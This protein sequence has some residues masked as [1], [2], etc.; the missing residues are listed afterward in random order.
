MPTTTAP[1]ARPV[2]ALRTFSPRVSTTW[3]GL[4]AGRKGAPGARA[5]SPA[6]RAL[7]PASP[8]EPP[9]LPPCDILPGWNSRESPGEGAAAETWRDAA[10][11]D[12][13]PAI[14]GEGK[15]PCGASEARLEL[16]SIVI[17]G[18][19]RGIVLSFLAIRGAGSTLEMGL[20]AQVVARYQHSEPV[21]GAVAPELLQDVLLQMAKENEQDLRELC[22]ETGCFKETQIVDFVFLLSEKWG[23]PEFARY[24]AIEIFE[25]F[26]LTLTQQFSFSTGAEQEESNCVLAR[27]QIVDTCVLRLVSCIQLASKLSFHYSIVNNAVVLKFLQSMGFSYTTE[28]LLES[29][30]G[31]LKA[32]HFQI[33]VPTPLAYIEML[34]EV[35]GYNG[36]LLPMEQMHAM[37]R[38]LLSLT[39]LLRVS[40][41]STLLKASIENTS[42]NKLQLAKFAAVKEDLMLL[43][44][45]IIGASAFLF[46]TEDWNQVAENLSD[47]TGISMRSIVEIVDAILKHSI[48]HA[49][50]DG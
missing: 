41:Y 24:Q 39:Y 45:G 16:Y 43:A 1:M 7:G 48:G 30:L 5:A 21:F 11:A 28:D 2:R 3:T 20:P 33:N 49:V 10:L 14:L 44:V 26:M 50:D 42:P 13:P 38:H 31:I 32:L 35:L 34:L 29:E 18:G 47:T 40:V 36:C 25:R 27:Q 9:P 37:C 4:E 19:E 46:H 8:E 15:R 23:L 17:S 22:D 6:C 12:A